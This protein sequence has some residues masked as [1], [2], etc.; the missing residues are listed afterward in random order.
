MKLVMAVIQ[1]CKLDGVRQRLEL[2]GVVGMTVSEV[3]GAGRLQSGSVMLPRFKIELVVDDAGVEQVCE[4]IEDAAQTGAVGDGKIFIS[5]VG[6][7]VRIRTGET[8][9]AAL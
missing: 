2:A 6:E 1:P 8:G 5:D 3:L 7:V 4:A 9:E